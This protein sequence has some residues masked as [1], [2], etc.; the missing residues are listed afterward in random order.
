MT[1][2]CPSFGF[3]VSI[4]LVADLPDDRVDTLWRSFMAAVEQRGLVADGGT[5]RRT[6]TYM[7]QSDASQATDADRQAIEAW[8][9]AQP[10]IASVEVG[11]LVDLHAAL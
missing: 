7:I 10:E 2:P 4:A 9:A 8:A 5:A 11:E 3:F 6:W 1:A